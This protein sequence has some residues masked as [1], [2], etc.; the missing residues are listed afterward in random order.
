MLLVTSLF[1]FIIKDFKGF[2]QK[3]DI[4]FKDALIIGLFQVIALIPGISRSGATIVGSMFRS[5]D[6]QTAFDFSFI[7]FIPISIAT[8]I[9]G[10]K[11]LLTLDLTTTMI[12][13]YLLA[14]VVAGIFTYFSMKL[15]KKIMINGKLIY[16]VIYCLIVGTSVVLF[17]R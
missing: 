5:L 4:T 17:L 3:E 14:M 16:F 8:S 6:R 1:L 11:D 9:L 10:I 15:F 2:K 12:G 7:L 13:Y